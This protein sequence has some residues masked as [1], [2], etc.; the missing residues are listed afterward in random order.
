MSNLR[1]GRHRHLTLVM[2]SK[3]YILSE[4]LHIFD[5]A[6]LR[7]LPTKYGKRT[8][9]S[10]Q[11]WK[12]LTKPST[13]QKIHRRRWIPKKVDHQRGYH[14]YSCTHWLTSCQG[15]DRF[16]LYLCYNIYL[17]PMGR[18]KIDLK[19]NAVKTMELYVPIETPSSWKSNWKREENPHV[20]EGILIP[21][22]WWYAKG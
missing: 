3:E 2:T 4:G 15:L 5:T 10:A 18:L 22:K 7:Q 20:Q 6:Q 14:Q 21:T 13:I 11:N 19:K 12:V 1:E 8:T 17:P 16:P 9:A